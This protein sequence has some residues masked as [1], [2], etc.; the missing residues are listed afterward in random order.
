MDYR[1][2][3]KSD[4]QIRSGKPCVSGTRISVFDVLDYLAAGMS[5]EEVLA[6]FPQLTRE[7]VLACL[8]YA[9]DRERKVAPSQA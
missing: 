7:S 6:D 3:I 5:V 1:P 8:A 4:P 9:A 2:Y